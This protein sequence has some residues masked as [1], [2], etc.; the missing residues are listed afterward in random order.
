MDVAGEGIILTIV[1]DMSY[2]F[3]IMICLAVLGVFRFLCFGVGNSAISLPQRRNTDGY[4]N[5]LLCR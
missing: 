2:N 4:F 1:S 3:S 5:G